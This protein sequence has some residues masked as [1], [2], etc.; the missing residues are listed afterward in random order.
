LWLGVKPAGRHL[1]EPCAPGTTCQDTVSVTFLGVGG[2]VIR[3]GPDAVMTAPLFT[4]PTLKQVV[5]VGG[6]DQATV[7]RML[8]KVDTAGI[9]AILVGH[10]HYD[11]LMDVP[12]LMHTLRKPSVIGSATTRHV[13]AGDPTLD[14]TRVVAI[15]TAQSASASRPGRWHYVSDAAGR[16]RFRVMAVMSTHAPNYE[17]VTISNFALHEDLDALP[18][19]P[20]DWPKGEVFAYVIDVLHDERTVAFR[21]Y[22]QD[23]ASDSAHSVR[24]MLDAGDSRPFDLVIV[25]GGNFNMAGPYPANVLEAF[26]PAYAILGHW[27]SFFRDADKSPWL[28]PMLNGRELKR[29]MNAA[30]ENRWAAV[31][32]L[33]TVLFPVAR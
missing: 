9:H 23:S 7:D 29:R 8:A 27:D 10:S 28:I 14:R 26:A 2:F 20:F 18:R 31:R 4:R 12:S 6:S 33:S 21:V 32:P 19:T 16:R 11:H 25:C 24:P 17:D 3:Y 13:L 5:R 1:I 22:Y 30:A 15:D